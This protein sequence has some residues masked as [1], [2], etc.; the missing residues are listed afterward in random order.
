M[1][2]EKKTMSYGGQH[3]E[4][5]TAWGHSRMTA[6]RCWMRRHTGSGV[7]AYPRGGIT[8]LCGASTAGRRRYSSVLGD[9]CGAEG[10]VRR[11]SAPAKG[12]GGEGSAAYQGEGGEA[13]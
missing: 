4:T 2:G 10:Q 5:T 11:L 8:T 9:L 6:E 12:D 3:G 13:R 1:E 7:A